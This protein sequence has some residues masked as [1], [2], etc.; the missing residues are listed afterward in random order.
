L[1]EGY[2]QLDKRQGLL[3]GLMPGGGSKGSD[4]ADSMRLEDFKR[5]NP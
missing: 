3:E 4:A 5:G 2:L 1:E